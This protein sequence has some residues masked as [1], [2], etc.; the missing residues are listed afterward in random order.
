MATV[1]TPK[2]LACPNCGGPI[3]IRGYAHTLSVVCPRCL[4]VLDATN[5][6]LAILQ[7]F[8][9]Q[10]RILPGIP[11]GS[12]GTFDGT[13]WE[14]I[15]F[16]IREVTTEDARY[17]WSEYLLFNPYKGFRYL[18]EYN[19]HWNYIRVIS[20]LPEETM[21][22]GKKAVRYQGKT[23]LHFDHAPARTSYVLGE[24]PWQVVV[25]EP[26]EVDDYIAPPLMLSSETMAG[27][28][29][30][31]LGEYY[32]GQQI[33]QAFKLPGRPNPPI[34]V[35]ANQPSPMGTRVKSMWTTWLW[36]MVMFVAMVLYF[37]V[38]AGR[39]EVFRQKYSFTPG[40]PS[41]A[42][43]VTNDFEL[44]GRASSVQIATSTDLQ[45]DWVYFNFALID[46]TTG[47]ARDFGREVSHYSDEGS[48]RDSVVLPAVPAGK[49]YLRVEPEKTAGSAPVNYEIVVR[50][51]VP[52]F[53]WFVLAGFLLLIPPIVSTVRIASFESARWR[54]SDYPPSISGGDD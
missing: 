32:T 47:K 29:T 46:E 44:T 33:W 43:F 35:F 38:S 9:G 6:Q 25:G 41:A 40:G 34:G 22:R 37:E 53:G 45:N 13:Q 8:Q 51:D 54:E 26:A 10:Q 30:W 18:S 2:A 23:F 42:A 39:H 14:V 21:A 27:E 31:S 1:A 16:Q 15:G 4:T 48:P 36:L 11:L 49:Y 19:G 12:R 28:I 5:P 7:K 17:G 50:R 20:A 52:G 3:E 24:F